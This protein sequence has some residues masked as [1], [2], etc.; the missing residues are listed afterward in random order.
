MNEVALSRCDTAQTL[1]WQVADWSP[2]A[3]VRT[4]HS[5]NGD[6]F[7]GGAI[8]VVVHLLVLALLLVTQGDNV[9]PARPPVVTIEIGQLP[10]APAT[11]SVQ[12]QAPSAPPPTIQKPP[13]PSAPVRKIVAQQPVPNVIRSAAS[14]ERGSDTLSAAPPADAA[15]SEPVPAESKVASAS[16]SAG[17]GPA[18]E[19]VP[20]GYQIGSQ[21]TPAPGYPWNARRRGH[22][23]K[24]VVRLDVD[25]E[26]HP[27][28]ID[29]VESSGDDE[30]DEAALETLRNW[31]L[32]P[33][34]VNG[35]P[36]SGR[37]LVPIQF[38]LN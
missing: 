28:K 4:G 2:S 26:G 11:P 17:S 30:L 3:T 5:E 15:S 36:V 12:P 8:S 32:R 34:T 7:W 35:R 27:G 6:R 1:P 10:Q 24:V 9:Q 16:A 21:H 18:A 23:G 13:Q 22:E 33:A 31:H 14:P 37:V 29:L 20:P 38:K 19:S 25:A